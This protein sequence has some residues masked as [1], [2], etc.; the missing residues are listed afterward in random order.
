MRK[1]IFSLSPQCSAQYPCQQSQQKI[2]GSDEKIV[3]VFVDEFIKVIQYR[4]FQFECFNLP[5]LHDVL[6]RDDRLRHRF[7]TT[8]VGKRLAPPFVLAQ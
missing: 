7:N 1:G 2:D 4:D 6:L 5:M 8:A 3:G